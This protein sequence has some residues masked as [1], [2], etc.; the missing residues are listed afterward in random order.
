MKLRMYDGQT[1]LYNNL[2]FA[3][4]GYLIELQSGKTWEQ[5]VKERIFDPLQMNSTSYSTADMTSEGG[6]S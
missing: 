6:A 2:M 5:F 4:V 1:F 3:V